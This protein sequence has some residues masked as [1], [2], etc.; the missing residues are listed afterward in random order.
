[1]L[2]VVLGDITWEE[3]EFVVLLSVIFLFSFFRVVSYCSVVNN[4]FRFFLRNVLKFLLVLFFW[5][6]RFVS[7]LIFVRSGFFRFMGVDNFW[8]GMN[9][10][11][12]ISG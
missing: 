10:N 12:L 5:V 7:L 1:M 8:E 6:M 4:F 2:F 9:I 3:G 11:V